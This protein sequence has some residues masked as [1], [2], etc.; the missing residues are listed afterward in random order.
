MFL[1]NQI[2]GFLNKLYLQNEKMKKPNF[3]MLIQIHW[4]TLIIGPPSYRASYKIMLVC[5]SIH[6]SVQ[7]FPQEWHISFFWFLAR[8]QIIGIFKNWLI[9]FS[10][11]IHFCPGL[12]RKGQN[13]HMAP[14]R[15]FWIF[16][17]NLSLVFLGSNL[18]WKL[19]SLLIFQH[20]PH[21]WQNSGP[22]VIAP[23]CCQP[24]KLQGSLKCNISRK[25]WM[26]NFT[27]GMLI[28]I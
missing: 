8:W 16:L 18:K 28:N 1:A 6:L 14:K 10:R 21:I 5:L 11:K 3:C 26:M 9:R 27:F 17:K 22:L 20:Q 23:I 25:K 24:I 12:A 15:V 13:G 4:I 19:I 7:H 2:T